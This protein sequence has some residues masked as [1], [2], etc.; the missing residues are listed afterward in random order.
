MED[1]RTANAKC[2]S[3]HRFRL[4]NGLYVSVDFAYSDVPEQVEALKVWNKA[5][6]D[7]VSFDRENPYHFPNIKC[8]DCSIKEIN[9]SKRSVV[10]RTAAGVIIVPGKSLAEGV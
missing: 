3:C 1:I 4:E 9:D 6:L 7:L 8:S 2:S 5:V 10:I